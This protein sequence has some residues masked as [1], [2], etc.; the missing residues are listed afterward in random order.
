MA[1]ERRVFCDTNFLLDVCDKDRLRHLDA[2]ALLWYAETNASAV[3]LIASASSFKDAYYVLCRLYH[4]E[5]SARESIEGLMGKL[6]HPVD[7]LA[8]YGAEALSSGEPDFEDGLIRACA[9]HE[10]ACVIIT[11]DKE[12]FAGSAVPALSA[13]AFLKHERFD[14]AVIDL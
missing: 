8:S 1:I 2:I 4:D 11:G 5:Q 10:G 3:K 6:V 14:Y 13:A 12:A 7:L 9:E